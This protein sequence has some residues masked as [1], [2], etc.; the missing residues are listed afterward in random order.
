MKKIK[1]L[2]LVLLAMFLLTSNVYGQENTP[3]NQ[4]D[5]S[6]IGAILLFIII[7]VNAILNQ[8]LFSGFREALQ[9][10][11]II[12]EAE[13]QYLRSSLSVQD[14]IKL[15]E[16]GIVFGST[17]DIP[18]VDEYLEEA[19]EFIDKVTDGKENK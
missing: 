4:I 7:I 14:F 19:K 13:K 6:F 16:S 8:R 5:Y 17:L 11:E 9:R 18:K 15:I 2:M 3:I 10:R 1:M 12:D